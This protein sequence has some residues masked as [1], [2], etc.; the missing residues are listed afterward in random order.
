MLQNGFFNVYV[1]FLKIK[2]SGAPLL[3]AGARKNGNTH[4]S[5]CS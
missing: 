2:R 4:A 5:A 1:V 3:T